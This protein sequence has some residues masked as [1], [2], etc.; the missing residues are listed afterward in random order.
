MTRPYTDLAPG[1]LAVGNPDR[2][3]PRPNRMSLW[4]VVILLLL[5]GGWALAWVSDGLA[6]VLS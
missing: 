5:A 6:E 2:F 3:D 1:I 4:R